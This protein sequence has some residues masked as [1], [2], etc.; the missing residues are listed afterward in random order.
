MTRPPPQDHFSLSGHPPYW[1]P[2]PRPR[3]QVGVWPGPLEG[4]AL[5]LHLGKSGSWE[6]ETYVARVYLEVSHAS[7]TEAN[8]D[9]KVSPRPDRLEELPSECSSSRTCTVTGQDTPL[10]QPD[11][12]LGP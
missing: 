4:P 8:P 12:F 9:R 3:S 2:T 6:P 11:L 1:L 5:L 10:S 7:A